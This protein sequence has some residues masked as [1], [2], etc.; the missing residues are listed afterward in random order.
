MKKPLFLHSM[1]LNFSDASSGY[2][3]LHPYKW[4]NRVHVELYDKEWHG[5]A[6]GLVG[7]E[8]YCTLIHLVSHKHHVST[9]GVLIGCSRKGL[10]T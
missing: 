5:S 6:M 9:L 3:S 4:W 1:P 10:V 8:I 2:R 7:R